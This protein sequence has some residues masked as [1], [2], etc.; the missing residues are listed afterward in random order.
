VI[1][2]LPICWRSPH[3]ISSTVTEH[4]EVPAHSVDVSGAACPRTGSGLDSPPFKP[5]FSFSSLS[6]NQFSTETALPPCPPAYHLSSSEFPLAS[7]FFSSLTK[8][9]E[10]SK[11]AR[12][13]MPILSLPTPFSRPSIRLRAER[14]P[15]FPKGLFLSQSAPLAFDLFFS[16]LTTLSPNVHAY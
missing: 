1:E 11:G 7:F 14:L 10:L 5:A 12:F 4:P 3:P 2:L 8:G 15:P 13:Y 6:S 16:D 9:I